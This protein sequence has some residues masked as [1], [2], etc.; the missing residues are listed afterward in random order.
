MEDVDDHFQIIEHDPLARWKSVD[1][2]GASAMVFAQAR[3]DLSSDRFQLGLRVRRTNNEKIGEAGNARE[4]ED[5]D[6][7]RLFV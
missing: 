7:F 4:V 2:R 3:F 1:R 5:D 6:I